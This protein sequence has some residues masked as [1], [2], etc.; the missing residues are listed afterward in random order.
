MILF[1]K[2]LEDIKTLSRIGQEITA[3]MQV[4]QIIKIVHNNLNLL[5]DAPNFEIGIYK[6]HKQIVDYYGYISDKVGIK[7][8]SSPVEPTRVPD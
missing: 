2:R 6:E 7:H 5:M 1:R 8:N 4:I 3:S